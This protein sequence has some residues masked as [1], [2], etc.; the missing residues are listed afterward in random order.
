MSA[1]KWTVG[2]L[3][4]LS[5]NIG[6]ND[7]D[8][9]SGYVLDITTASG[10]AQMYLAMSIPNPGTGQFSEPPVY[11]NSALTA[12][13]ADDTADALKTAVDDLVAVTGSTLTAASATA[14][15]GAAAQFD[16]AAWQNY[17]FTIS[18]PTEWGPGTE[19]AQLLVDAGPL[20][21]GDVD[22]VT[23]ALATFLEGLD[24][25]TGVSMAQAA[26]TPSSL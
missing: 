10:A 11:S 5:V 7:Y 19:S 26:V 16:T 23:A 9:G 17:L 24:T 2:N 21:S 6:G 4:R 1:V 8:F 20:S 14:G 13:D 15:S 25:V 18:L 12:T 22:T 3:G